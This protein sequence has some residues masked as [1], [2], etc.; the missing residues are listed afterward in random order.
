MCVCA[1]VCGHNLP[2]DGVGSTAQQTYN[3]LSDT[4]FIHD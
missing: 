4:W 1:C 2:R 3:Q